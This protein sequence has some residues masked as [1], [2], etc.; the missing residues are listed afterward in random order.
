MGVCRSLMKLKNDYFLKYTKHCHFNYL[1]HS[2]LQ[3]PETKKGKKQ[4]ERKENTS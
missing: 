4:E 3:P 1:F 2:F